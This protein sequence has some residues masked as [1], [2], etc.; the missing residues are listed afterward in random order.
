M[1]PPPRRLNGAT[2]LALP[3]SLAISLFILQ[4]SKSYENSKVAR[5]L[6]SL[7]APLSSPRAAAAPP[8]EWL[9]RLHRHLNGE[10][11]LARPFSEREKQRETRPRAASTPPV[12]EPFIDNLLVRIH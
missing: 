6:S 8:L 2:S 7:T 10:I 11:S 3:L 4:T 12:G 9:S 5:P 1:L